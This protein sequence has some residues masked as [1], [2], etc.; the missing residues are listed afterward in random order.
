LH[1]QKPE[2]VPQCRWLVAY[3]ACRWQMPPAHGAAFQPQ[4]N[5]RKDSARDRQRGVFGPDVFADLPRVV[6][7]RRT[8]EV[9]WP[10][11]DFKGGAEFFASP[12]A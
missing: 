11:P 4:V 9:L 7:E 1:L 2:C 12:V 6:A 8:F 10:P 3:A 5:H